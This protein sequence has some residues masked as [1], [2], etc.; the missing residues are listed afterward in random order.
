M[1]LPPDLAAKLEHLQIGLRDDIV[2]TRQRAGRGARYVFH[3]PITFRNHLFSVFEYQIAAAIVPDRTLAATFAD[4]VARG[5]LSEKRKDAFY[6]FILRLHGM[7]LIQLPIVEPEKLFE[8]YEAR[9]NA[10]LR[11]WYR[12]AI[13]HKLPLLNPDQFLERSLRSVGWIYSKFGFALW[14]LL[15]ATVAWH[16][17]GRLPDVLGQSSQLLTLSNLPILWIT[18]I[19]LKLVHEFGHAYACRR[20]GGE[21]PE[22]GAVF[23]L[24]TPCAYVDAS[25]SWKFESKWHRIAVALGGM[26]V[27]SIVAGVAALVWAGTQ[28]GLVHD[29]ALNIVVMA[30]VVTVLFNINPLVKFDG[31]FVVSDLLGVVNLQQ[32]ASA[33]LQDVVKRFALGLPT[34]SSWRATSS[35]RWVYATYAPAA[36]AYRV[37]LAFALTGIAVSNWPGIGLVLGGLFAWSLIVV[38]VRRGFS[39][40]WSAEETEPVRFR[41]RTVGLGLAVLV[42]ALLAFLP[43]STRVVVP[44]VLDPGTRASIRAP[45]SG[46]VTREV[47]ANGAK[48]TSGDL[49]CVLDNPDLEV[50][51]LQLAGD[52]HAAQIEADVAEVRDISRASAMRQRVIFAQA[53]L[54]EVDARLQTAAIRCPTDGTVVSSDPAGWLGRWVS[55]G[56]ELLQIHALNRTVRVVLTDREVL[57]AKLEPGSA[58]EILWTCDTSRPVRAVVREIRRSASRTDVPVEVTMLA[59]GEVYAEPDW[60]QQTHADRPYLHVFLEAESAPFDHG[61]A[62]LT[63]RVRLTARSLTLGAWLQQTV[64]G[65]Y[66]AWKMS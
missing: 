57:R 29:V 14:G 33:L 45:V 17:A 39:Y 34:P 32:R 1:Q 2:V 24:L 36:F 4:L 56:E 49:L 13:Y 41:A 8:R 46:F 42:A 65:V 18:L 12:V 55:Q 48:V 40:L 50:R 21:V 27:E 43:V 5:T 59:G 62:G 26:Y 25:S 9:R 15:M 64:L 61:G 10:Q 19:G 22:M 23:I 31:Y 3:D 35:P 7:G 53:Q 58:A 47:A 20:W 51:K 30:S 60:G 28:P 38:P 63:A 52:V 11:G 6:A 37:F 44:G 66:D 16:C 54:T